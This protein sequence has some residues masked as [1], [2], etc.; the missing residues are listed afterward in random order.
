M[1]S[2]NF[3]RIQQIFEQA[4]DLPEAERA[5][6]LEEAC[7][8]DTELRTRVDELLAADAELDEFLEPPEGFGL[9]VEKLRAD[10]EDF[11]PE[12]EVGGY[13]LVRE[14]GRGGRGVVYLA[15]DPKSKALVALKI[16]GSGL[17]PSAVAVERFRREAKANQRVDH[18][19]IVKLR[20][21]GDDAGRP[22]LVMDYIEGHTLADEILLQRSLIEPI[23][24]PNHLRDRAPILPPAEPD[25]LQASV[26]LVEQMGEALH[27][28]HERGILHRDVKPQNVLLDGEGKPH[29]IDFG[30][31][32]VQGEMSLTRT[33]EV[34]GTPNYMS[35][36]QVRALKGG[37]DLRTDVYSLG[38]VLYE[39]LTL[40]RPFDAPTANQVM[41][42][43]TRTMP[44]RI[45]R[46]V[47]TVPSSLELICTTAIEKR[48][49]HRY[50]SMA[51]FAA[52]LGAF[53]NSRPLNAKAPSPWTRALRRVQRRPMPY[54]VSLAVLFSLGLGAWA[55]G[56]WSGW[57]DVRRAVRLIEAA[58]LHEQEFDLRPVLT[59]VRALPQ[60]REDLSDSAR[61]RL[62]ELEQAGLA[63]ARRAIAAAFHDTRPVAGSP[64]RMVNPLS[65]SGEAIGQAVGVEWERWGLNAEQTAQLFDESQAPYLVLELE[66]SG[67]ESIDRIEVAPN[68]IEGLTPGAWVVMEPW[69]QDGIIRVPPNRLATLRLQAVDGRNWEFTILPTP[70]GELRRLV[71]GLDRINDLSWVE[72][73]AVSVNVEPFRA[74]LRDGARSELD[75]PALRM[76]ETPMSNRD[77]LRFVEATQLT[78]LS[79]SLLE[80]ESGWRRQY[81]DRPAVYVTLEEAAACAAWYGVRLATALEW[82]VSA[83]GPSLPLMPEGLTPEQYLAIAESTGFWRDAPKTDDEQFLG[84][85]WYSEIVPPITRNGPL[86][87]TWSGMRLAYGGVFELTSTDSSV[88]ADSGI[89]GLYLMGG[90]AAGWTSAFLDAPEEGG[91]FDFWF[92]Q[93]LAMAI[94]P[95]TGFRCAAPTERLP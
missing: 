88:W 19:G 30:L 70:Q 67:W 22:F 23:E 10:S 83:V 36:E 38:V 69:G 80:T 86:D 2:P 76:Q 63:H 85:S 33:G 59:A 55:A 34:E 94:Q 54:A 39:L 93:M 92:N 29:L 89:E 35:P 78:S 37:I 42:N 7:G 9:P 56:E 1:A 13:R 26:R 44:P 6:F 12:E 90:A 75:L 61:D 52:D 24:L 95:D 43:I 3:S 28:A 46:V 66:G 65:G 16:L 62:F 57:S 71:L 82:L 81:A 74:K 91:Q 45:R 41:Q 51:T 87:Q 31:A 77:F 32:E 15:E 53:L 8:S 58:E 79:A 27:H 18:P 84:E 60:A 72:V 50:A 21:A 73:P 64:S 20:L 5:R 17:L 14:L 4:L 25:R 47:P 49:E 11:L 68:A 48:P 40:R